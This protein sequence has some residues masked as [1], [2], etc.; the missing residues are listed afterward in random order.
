M[1]NPSSISRILKNEK[2]AGILLMPKTMKESVLDTSYKPIKGRKINIWYKI[3][4][5]V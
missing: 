2:Y 3:I 1:W 5:R 4:M